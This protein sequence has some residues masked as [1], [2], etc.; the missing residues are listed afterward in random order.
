[1]RHG[2]KGGGLGEPQTEIRAN[3][4]KSGV[5]GSLEGGPGGPLVFGPEDGQKKFRKG[6]GEISKNKK[7]DRG[8]VQVDPRG[9]GSPL[10]G[11]YKKRTC[12]S[13]RRTRKASPRRQ[14]E[15]KVYLPKLGPG[16]V[17]F[18]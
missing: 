7:K 5:I 13:Y 4:K 1:M 12:T 18:D 10:T 3:R 6:G 14:P 8:K 9:G 2:G 17:G 16:A 11:T 15:K